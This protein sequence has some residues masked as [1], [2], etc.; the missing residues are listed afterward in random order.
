MMDLGYNINSEI[1]RGNAKVVENISI[2]TKPILL[3]RINRI[4]YF[5]L[6]EEFTY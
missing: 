3:G 1:V 6:Y 2:P 5:C 4:V